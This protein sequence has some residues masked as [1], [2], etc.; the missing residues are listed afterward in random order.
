[1][2]RR[3]AE[4]FTHE[5]FENPHIP[6]IE[7]QKKLFDTLPHLIPSATPGLKGF[8][9][10]IRTVDLDN[11][12]QEY[13]IKNPN[14]IFMPTTSPE[15]AAMAKQCST[16]TLDELI[17]TKRND[18]VG[19]GWMYTPPN[20]GS[21]IAAVS[22]GALGTKDG[23]SKA[24]D[25]AEYRQW[26]FDL[27]LAKKQVLLDK[28]KAMKACTEVDSDVFKGCGYCKDINQGVP[29][30]NVG[31]PLYQSDPR[32]NCNPDAIVR[33]SGDCPPPPTPG[34]GP[35]PIVDRTC[36]PVNGRLSSMCL[37]NQ[38]LQG[39]CSDSGALAVAL[40]TS[41][42]PNNYVGNL[43][44]SDS[45][46]VYNRVANP[47][48]KMDIF[49]DGRSTAATALQEVRN[50]RGN[51]SQPA[52]SAIGAAARDLCLQRGA[53]SGYDLCQELSDGSQA[54]FDL[55]CL[56]D[57][58][59]KMG[60]QPKGTAY[61]TNANIA[62]YNAKGTIGAVKQ[63]ISD[64]VAKMGVV[65]ENFGQ[66]NSFGQESFG[67]E[68]FG[69]RESFAD[70]A[71]QSDAMTQILGIT[72]DA[73]IARAPYTQGVEVFWFAANPGD[74]HHVGPFLRRTVEPSIWM[75]GP[76]PSYVQQVGMHGYTAA[77]QLFDYRTPVNVQTRFR[78]NVD[79]GF[80]V[81]AN[82]PA[83]IDA[84][85]MSQY[86]VDTPGLFENLGLQGPTTYQSNA[87][88]QYNAATPNITKLYWEDAGGGWQSFL[89]DVVGCNGSFNFNQ[90]MYSL[91]CEPNA[92]FIN[93]EV[94]ESGRFEELRNPGIFAQ[95]MDVISLDLHTRTD[96][97]LA[98]PGK[99]GFVRMN[100][101]SQ[102]DINNVCFQ[103]WK[104]MTV[105]M[106]FNSMP[107]KESII[108]LAMGDVGTYMYNLIITPS[109]GNLSGMHVEYN[110][111]NGR[112]MIGTPFGF[113]LNT[114]Y[115]FV[116]QMKGTGVHLKAYNVEGIKNGQTEIPGV[117]VYGKQLFKPNASWYQ[118]IPGT[119]Y[120][121]CN[122][123][124]GSAK[125]RNG[126]LA[127]YATPSF[128]YDVAWVHFFDYLITHDDVKRECAADWIYTAFPKAY[129]KY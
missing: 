68:S 115:I 109:S 104:T 11:G 85:A 77:L 103:S 65:K 119:N 91:T 30:D 58:F 128:S 52:N 50:I 127:L 80:W 56:Q 110:I 20:K 126:W 10:G 2:F 114:W 86:S 26:F 55:K 51:M 36:D 129:N 92:P 29:I 111:G 69:Q 45:V 14:D 75:S 31:R 37:Y 25:H 78:I 33:S 38:V 95:R 102:I 48:L 118:G 39:G 47:P 83:N 42:D 70:Y 116:I 96:E 84:Y 117:S 89:F 90:N 64:L 62:D 98:V 82:Q 34:S 17:A 57:I 122:A 46:K 28:C 49:K 87:C 97:K 76:G 113:A 125:Y 73:V 60:G 93:F 41:R 81:A 44:N 21:A 94:T 67:Q 112:Q 1:M 5:G 16:G 121:A 22:A 123:L 3:L 100:S 124:I 120:Q 107:V 72:P 105:C 24:F 53:I 15:L 19:C 108:N 99:K 63:Y 101:N 23:A 59:L 54:P 88:T 74:V 106:R 40:L 18:A 35:Q 4:T 79:D 32:G 66:R 27:Q 8:D 9:I 6:F 43:P 7:K 61:P 71:T 13:S 12:Y